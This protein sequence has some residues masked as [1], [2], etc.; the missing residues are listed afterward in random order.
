VPPCAGHRRDSPRPRAGDARWRPVA[1]GVPSWPYGSSSLEELNSTRQPV[2]PSNRLCR[3]RKKLARAVTTRA[4]RRTRVGR[5]NRPILCRALSSAT[6]PK[7]ETRGS[8]SLVLP[9]AFEPERGF[10]CWVITKPLADR[11]AEYGPPGAVGLRFAL[12]SSNWEGAL[13]RPRPADVATPSGQDS[14][15]WK[16]ASSCPGLPSA[17]SDSRRRPSILKP[18]SSSCRT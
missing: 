18:S 3:P 2:C 10:P 8:V 5:D 12:S 7:A 1:G 15:P 16:S 13:S 11:R 4:W 6:S 9:S 14:K 17:Q